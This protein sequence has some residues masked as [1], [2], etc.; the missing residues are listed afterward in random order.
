MCDL[1]LSENDVRDLYWRRVITRG[2]SGRGL[3]ALS[4]GDD[5]LWPKACPWARKII[6]R[7]STGSFSI[8]SRVSGL[9][10]CGGSPANFGSFAAAAGAGGGASFKISV[11]ERKAIRLPSGAQVK[12]SPAPFK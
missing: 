1:K 9:N 4:I 11:A 5:G 6:S 7:I 12:L 10:T 2:S 8:S 3:I